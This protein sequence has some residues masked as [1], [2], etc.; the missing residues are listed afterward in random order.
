MG[1]TESNRCGNCGEIENVKHVL[2]KCER[3]AEEREELCDKVQE[4]G[5]EWDIVG[6]LGAEGKGVGL[7]RKALLKYLNDTR[8]SNRI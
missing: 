8:L 4:E 1:K 6:I 7:V 2:L 3:Y 5:R